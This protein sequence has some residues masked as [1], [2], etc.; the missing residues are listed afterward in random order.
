MT[1]QYSNPINLGTEEMPDWEYQQ[2]DCQLE[3]LVSQES[4]NGSFY[5]MNYWTNGEILISFILV[6]MAVFIITKWIFDFFFPRIFKL[7]R[8]N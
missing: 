4:E 5:V 1:C 2:S 3:Y 6:L 8:K 7:K